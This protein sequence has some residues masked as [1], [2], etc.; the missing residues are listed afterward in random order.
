MWQYHLSEENTTSLFRIESYIGN[1]YEGQHLTEVVGLKPFESREPCYTSTLKTE[2][3]CFSDYMVLQLRKL[4]YQ[5]S[6]GFMQETVHLQNC[7]TDF[8]EL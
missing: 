4:K 3:V 8:E 7:S 1:P 6:M 2:G 5:S